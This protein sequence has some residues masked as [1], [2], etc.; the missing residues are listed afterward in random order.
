MKQSILIYDDDPEIL[1]VSKIIL[2]QKDYYVR[3]R[4]RCNNIIE[5]ISLERPDII[6]MDIWIPEMGGEQALKFIKNNEN[7]RQIPVI[8]FSALDNIEEISV[9][10]NAN[11]YLKK[12][13]SI[14]DLIEIVEKNIL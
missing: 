7:T 2:E 1:S 10:S 4:E 14:E 8:L 6:L 3:T 13:F 5:D 9:R 12:P 11:G